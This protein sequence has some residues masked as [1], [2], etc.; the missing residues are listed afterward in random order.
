MHGKVAAYIAK[1]VC[2]V[3]GKG[4]TLVHLA[5]E[6]VLP[7]ECGDSIPLKTLPGQH[8]GPP[9]VAH[10]E[11]NRDVSLSSCEDYTI[12]IMRANYMSRTSDKG[13]S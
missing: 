10:Q 11:M 13:V 7:H 9:R 5:R 2:Y 12:A 3:Q 6:P 4:L 8:P 1:C